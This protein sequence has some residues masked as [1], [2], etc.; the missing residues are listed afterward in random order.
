MRLAAQQRLGF[1][2]ANPVAIAELAKHLYPRGPDPTKR[3]DTVNIL[4]K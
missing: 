1:Y 4:W 2:P 3:I